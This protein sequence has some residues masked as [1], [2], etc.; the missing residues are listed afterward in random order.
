M[1]RYAC[2]YVDLV[3]PRQCIL[4]WVAVFLSFSCLFS[5]Q[6]C[7]CNYTNLR[8]PSCGC[9]KPLRRIL[10]RGSFRT[11]PR[12]HQALLGGPR[13][14]A[15]HQ[16]GLSHGR[17]APASVGFAAA[18]QVRSRAAAKRRAHASH[19]CSRMTTV[20]APEKERERRNVRVRSARGA[21]AAAPLPVPPLLAA[22]APASMPCAA[23]R[24]AIPP[25]PSAWCRTSR[26][27]PPG[28]PTHTQGDNDSAPPPHA[29]RWRWGGARPRP[30]PGASGAGARA[31]TGG[32]RSAPRGGRGAPPARACAAAAARGRAGPRRGSRWPSSPLASWRPARHVSRAASRCRSER[33]HS[34]DA[35]LAH[36][37]VLGPRRPLA[38][39]GL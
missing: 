9:E 2:A 1:E 24:N 8:P 33:R 29:A 36:R 34:A 39:V 12:L 11:P 32:R 10:C 15:P 26:R 31:G 18:P 22:A 28:A 3:R 38:R 6:S 19:R 35:A 23:F 5:W 14:A 16:Y 13:V 4:A 7:S 30:E 20:T 37:S 17:D 25:P 27:R 21:S